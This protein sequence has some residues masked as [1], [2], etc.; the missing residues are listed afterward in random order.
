MTKVGVALVGA[1]LVGKE[2]VHLLMSPALREVF[3]IVLLSNSK[4]AVVLETSTESDKA[5]AL[6]SLLPPSSSPR[7]PSSSAATYLSADPS[8]LVDLLAERSRST[9]QHIAFID[10]TSSD[11]VA[12]LYP[13]AISSSLSLVTP[14]KRAFSSSASLYKAIQV[15]LQRPKAGLCY[16]EATCGAGLPVLTT[17]RDLVLTGDEIVKV[18]AVLSGTLSYLF[19]QYSTIQSTKERVRF[20]ELVRD[21][22]KHGHTVSPRDERRVAS[23]LTARV[24][25]GTAPGGRPFRP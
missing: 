3:D 25:P 11:T 21:A 15:A 18:E 14:N 10:C 4:H 6:L 19:N 5:D 16:Y 22:W 2:V 7:P 17:V 8:R 12:A 9:S 1:G 23:E 20:S 13:R 24:P